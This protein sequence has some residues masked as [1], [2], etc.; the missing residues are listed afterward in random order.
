MWRKLATVNL[1]DAEDVA[2]EKGVLKKINIS[3]QEVY[4]ETTRT[5]S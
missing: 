2:S 5:V 4:G 3:V 1:G